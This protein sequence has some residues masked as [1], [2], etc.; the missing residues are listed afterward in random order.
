M[1]TGQAQADACVQIGFLLL[2]AIAF[3][4]ALADVDAGIE[5]DAARAY[6]DTCF[7]AAVLAG[8]VG[9]AVVLGGFDVEG[10]AFGR[11]PL[12][13]RLKIFRIKIF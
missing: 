6:R 5:A 11:G 12:L 4:V 2:Q 8:V 10:V 9:A 7:A 3:Q 1:A 13:P